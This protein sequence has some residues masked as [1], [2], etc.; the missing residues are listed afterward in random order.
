MQKLH[1]LRTPVWDKQVGESQQQFTAFWEWLVSDGARSQVE[2][3]RSNGLGEWTAEY[4]RWGERGDQYWQDFH[5]RITKPL[6]V[7][8]ARLRLQ[9][10][11]AALELTTRQTTTE[12]SDKG[13]RT[14]EHLPNAIV[15]TKVLERLLEDTHDD[16][17]ASTTA[18]L[19]E[20]MVSATTGSSQP[21]GAEGDVRDDGAV[22]R[23]PGGAA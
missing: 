2:V 9:A 20:A 1:L 18:K 7:R 12:T 17:D 6:E 23:E 8:L 21:S 16:L 11:D 3:C 5:Q 4:Y 22:Q 10:V 13:V 15:V 14:R 19:L